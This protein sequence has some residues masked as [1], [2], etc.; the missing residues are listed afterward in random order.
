MS[1]IVNIGSP[2]V[3]IG[4]KARRTGGI[5]AR[6]A[7]QVAELDLYQGW[8][9]Y[10]IP[11]QHQHWPSCVAEASVNWLEHMIRRFIEPS[12]IP[13]FCQLDAI[14]VWRR[15]RKMFWA[16]DEPDAGGL[17][18]DQAFRAM[19]DLHILPAETTVVRCPTIAEAATQLHH[20]PLIM[21]N[22]VTD[23]WMAGHVNKDTGEIASQIGR[24]IP[25]LSAGHATMCM[26]FLRQGADLFTLLQNSW[27][28]GWG[29]SGCGLMCSD[30]YNRSALD[31]FVTCQL[32]ADWTR[33]NGW[34][35]LLISSA[36][37]AMPVEV[38]A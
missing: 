24:V 35:Q 15:A 14:P 21:A 3:W 31:D 6:P 12:A 11:S 1:N 38:L 7:V 17:L 8:P 25:Y 2:S 23:G 19:I 4:C 34:Q 29:R 16:D 13:A 10:A 26:S 33:H 30:L 22:A 37:Q 32:P 36:D 18:L 27:G 28:T 5:G 20:T 9:Q